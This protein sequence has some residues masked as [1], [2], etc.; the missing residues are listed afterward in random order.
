[1]VRTFNPSTKRYEVTPPKQIT[2]KQRVTILEAQVVALTKA[3][4]K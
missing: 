2:L 4:S 3:L 1:M